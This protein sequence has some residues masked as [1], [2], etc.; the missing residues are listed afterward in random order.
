MTDPVDG[1]ARPSPGFTGVA[2][3]V[4]SAGTFGMSGIFA[5]ALIWPGQRLRLSDH[6][7]WIPLRT[8]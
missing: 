7:T 1:N 8:A 2:L 5:S 4:L 6:G 3:A